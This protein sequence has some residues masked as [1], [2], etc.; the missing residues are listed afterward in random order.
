MSNDEDMAKSAF[1]GGHFEFCSK[2]SETEIFGHGSSSNFDQYTIKVLY[3]N[4][5]ALIHPGN[6]NITKAP[7]Y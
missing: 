7:D 1:C 2:I 4:C 5:G 3:A 6:D